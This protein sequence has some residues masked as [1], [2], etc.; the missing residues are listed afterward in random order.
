MVFVMCHWN[1]FVL[2]I[3]AALTWHDPFIMTHSA[4]IIAKC[5]VF[6]GWCG[7]LSNY[8]PETNLSIARQL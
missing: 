4:A 2:S 8:T 3:A 6:L 5:N 1:K 7:V